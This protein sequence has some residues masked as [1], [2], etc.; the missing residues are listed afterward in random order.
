MQQRFAFA[1][2]IRQTK[3]PNPIGPNPT[4]EVVKTMHGTVQAAD[5]PEASHFTSLRQLTKW[6]EDVLPFHASSH[7]IPVVSKP[8]K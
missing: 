4:G 8:N 7:P 1:L 6:I 5:A 2:L 3:T